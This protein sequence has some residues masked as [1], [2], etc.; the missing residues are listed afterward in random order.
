MHVKA[1]ALILP[2]LAG[3]EMNGSVV[4]WNGQPQKNHIPD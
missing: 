3:A 2:F 4:G 1:Y